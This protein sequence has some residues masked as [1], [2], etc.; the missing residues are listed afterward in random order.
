[1]TD[2]IRS[3]TVVPGWFDEVAAA[4]LRGVPAAQR[5]EPPGDL[6]ELGGYLGRSAVVR[7]VHPA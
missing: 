4:L 7:R 5:D 6:V 1:M 2:D 3:Y